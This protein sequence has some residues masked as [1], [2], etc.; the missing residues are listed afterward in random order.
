MGQ[1]KVDI[2][3]DHKD[4]LFEASLKFAKYDSPNFVIMKEAIIAYQ[5]IVFNQIKVNGGV[6]NGAVS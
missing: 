2:L 6:S 1:T 4:Q 3:T 5:T